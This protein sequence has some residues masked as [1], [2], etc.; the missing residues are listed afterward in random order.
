MVDALTF[1]SL[2]SGTGILPGYLAANH[3]FS[4]LM[5]DDGAGGPDA[6][7][8]RNW[9]HE[10]RPTPDPRGRPPWPGPTYALEHLA[11]VMRSQGRAEGGSDPQRVRL[12]QLHTSKIDVKKLDPVG[13]AL[14]ET[15]CT[16]RS[17]ASQAMKHNRNEDNLFL[18]TS[19][20]AL[21]A[22]VTLAKE[23]LALQWLQFQNP[24]LVFQANTCHFEPG[25]YTRTRLTCARSLHRSRT[26]EAPWRS[27][28]SRKTASCSLSLIHI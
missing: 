14:L 6:L 11:E 22:D 4:G 1:L 18:G 25:F 20:E 10:R 12:L 19:R 23:L 27:T 2:C 17:N 26:R 28:R 8:P 24:R 9:W 13:V 16:T 5:I 7:L 21:E 15:C 3:G